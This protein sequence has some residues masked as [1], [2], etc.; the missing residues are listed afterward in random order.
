VEFFAAS[1]AR[2][3][4]VDHERI[5]AHGN[6]TGGAMAYLVG[7]ARREIIRGIIVSEA[8]LP[9]GMEVPETNPAAPLA[10]HMKTYSGSSLAER[11]AEDV[12]QI[13]EEKFPL[14][15]REVT[16][17]PPEGIEDLEG[18]GEWLDCLDRI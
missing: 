13:R 6:G 5:V 11:I 8:T 15:L 4:D 14:T 18:I 1:I 16:G 2:T 12:E 10:I 7:F 9:R 17:P 3:Y